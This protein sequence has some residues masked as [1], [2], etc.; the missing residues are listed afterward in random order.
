M[1]KLAVYFMTSSLIY[2]L[3]FIYMYFHFYTLITVQ[4]DIFWWKVYL[5]AHDNIE[6]AF[7]LSL[8]PLE[9]CNGMLFWKPTLKPFLWVYP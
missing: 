8:L 3:W 1:E 2:F 7:S 6:K 9:T 4:T 5:C